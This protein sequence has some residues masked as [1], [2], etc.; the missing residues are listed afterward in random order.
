M[1]KDK[2]K[3]VE[4]ENSEYRYIVEPI[5]YI[6]ITRHID[7]VSE[8]LKIR[9][10]KGK[11]VF[12]NGL[13]TGNTVGRFVEAYFDGKNFET[14]SFVTLFDVPED[15]R[16]IADEALEEIKKSI[17]KPPEEPKSTKRGKVADK[18]ERPSKVARKTKEEKKIE[19]KTKE[20]EETKTE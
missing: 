1:K 19:R 8:L 3:I 16:K 2:F 11:V 7:E 5:G 13:I 17:T 15:I 9:N 20:K 12:D 4:T 18:R 14:S 6:S 10:Y